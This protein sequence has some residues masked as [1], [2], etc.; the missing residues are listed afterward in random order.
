VKKSTQ[1]SGLYLAL[2]A[3]IFFGGRAFAYGGE[4]GDEAPGTC[5]PTPKADLIRGV[6]ALNWFSSHAGAG[7]KIFFMT[8]EHGK[9]IPMLKGRTL[10]GQEITIP[11]P[12][13]DKRTVLG[14]AFSPKAEADLKTWM[15][16][17]YD[18]FLTKPEGVFGAADSFD[19]H[20]YFIA[21]A[22]NV[23]GGVMEQKAKNKVDAELQPHI[24]IYKGDSAPWLKALDVKDKSVPYFL[25]LNEQGEVLFVTSGAYTE[26]KMEKISSLA[27]S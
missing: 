3:L 11:M 25:V 18:E 27:E 17:A 10:S 9:V 24:V 21:M 26:E 8:D 12:G 16:P 1:K 5:R 15:Q 7:W 14:L 20:I 2:L 6:P 19:G 4:G 23:A 13:D 22:G